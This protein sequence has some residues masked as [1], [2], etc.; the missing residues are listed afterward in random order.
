[1][2][3]REGSVNKSDI[4]GNLPCRRFEVKRCFDTLKRKRKREEKKEKQKDF[5]SFNFHPGEKL[6][7]VLLTK[8]VP[9]SFFGIGKVTALS[10]K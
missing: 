2:L 9:Q 8:V 5:C 6:H 4:Q 1:L 7:T 3:E 10:L